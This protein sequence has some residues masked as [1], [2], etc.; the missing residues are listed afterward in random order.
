MLQVSA[1]CWICS[2]FL[3]NARLCKDR[4]LIYHETALRSGLAANQAYLLIPIT[5]EFRVCTQPL[6]T[7][8]SIRYHHWWLIIIKKITTFFFFFVWRNNIVMHLIM[9]YQLNQHMIRRQY[10]RWNI[11]HPNYTIWKKINC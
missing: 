7:S 5:I 6:T 3:P 1:F 8:H 2:Y 4:S 11:F 10:I 9:K